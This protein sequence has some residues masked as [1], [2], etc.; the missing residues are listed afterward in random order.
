[1]DVTYIRKTT[2]IEVKNDYYDSN[3]DND[4]HPIIEDDCSNNAIAKDNTHYF[5]IKDIHSTDT[6]AMN[7]DL[8]SNMDSSDHTVPNYYDSTDYK[9]TNDEY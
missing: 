4:Y 9:T 6:T 8:H 2:W 3:K 7:N 1:M 5:A